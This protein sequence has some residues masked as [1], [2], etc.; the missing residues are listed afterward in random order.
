MSVQPG[1]RR[2]SWI[3]AHEASVA[4]RK[5]HDEEMR[6]MLHPG[7]ECICLAKVRLSMAWRMRQRH[8]H[9]PVAT[10]PFANVILDDGLSAREAMLIAKTFEDPLRRVALLTMDPST[11]IRS[12]ISVNGSSFGRFGG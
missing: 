10:A 7:D 5:R 11:R 8:E 12:M 6:P 3:G 9:L 4:V 1:F 2:R